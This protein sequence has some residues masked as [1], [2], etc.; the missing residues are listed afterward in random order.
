MSCRRS[1]PA[2]SAGLLRL[3]IRRSADSVPPPNGSGTDV[4]QDDDGRAVGYGHAE[5]GWLHVLGVATFRFGP[6]GVVAIA[7]ET[8]TSEAV[9]D[10]HRRLVLP[11]ALQA[12][13]Q[14]V[15]HASAVEFGA[16]AVA[17]CGKKTS[18]KTTVAYSLARRGHPECADDAVAV[19]LGDDGPELLPLP[20]AL[21]LRPASAAHYRDET[22]TLGVRRPTER[23]PLAAVCVLERGSHTSHVRRLTSV[24]AFPALLAHAYAFGIADQ[25]RRRQMI[26]HYLSLASEVPVFEVRLTSG[27]STLDGTLDEVEAAVA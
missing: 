17:F 6:H 5:D 22:R 26:E 18:G 9:R 21:R 8:V 16:G 11:L 15:L 4:W 12:L 14:E 7:P 23:L 10:A 13:G 27:L 3:T 19:E 20:F 25:G 1:L 2:A 24:D